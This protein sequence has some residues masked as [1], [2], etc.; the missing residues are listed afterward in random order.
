[1]K[2]KQNITKSASNL[3]AKQK[4]INQRASRLREHLVRIESLELV[5]TV[6]GTMKAGKSTCINTIVGHEIL[7]NRNR[8]MTSLPTLVHHK[9]GHRK[10]VLYFLH[11]DPI[12]RLTIK[13]GNALHKAS[14]I[15]NGLIDS[16]KELAN[17]A[18]RILRGITF[19]ERYRGEAE[20][21]SFL[22]TLNDLVR[23]AAIFNIEFPYKDYSKIENFPFIELEFTHFNQGKIWQAHHNV[24]FLDTPG[25][26]EAG[27]REPL[28]KVVK[29]QLQRADMVMLVID[30]TQ[31]KS[32][33]E[34]TL[35]NELIEITETT[36]GR[37]ITLVNKFDSGNEHSDNVIETT[38]YVSRTLLDGIVPAEHV[39]PVSA[40]Q[41]FLA[42]RAKHLL[43]IAPNLNWC[44]QK[45]ND[46]RDDFGRLAF[47]PRYARFINNRNATLQAS[48]DLWSS[49]MFDRA[50]SA[51]THY[52][53]TSDLPCSSGA[54]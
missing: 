23:L 25:G 50:L 36:Q 43:Q 53:P 29:E 39:F 28:R 13:I 35:I 54:G 46:W 21:F 16:D 18:A 15:R 26:N 5:I 8:P 7:P 33:S 6:V 45:S 52:R 40:K 4:I 31:L 38:D 27:L 51:I 17:L 10:P 47:G 3:I 30:Y 48:D 2:K 1:M 41:A 42:Q 49:S 37:I 11:T 12:Q 9:M 19:K 20:I 24:A 44:E 14:K 34:R 22:Q 32:E